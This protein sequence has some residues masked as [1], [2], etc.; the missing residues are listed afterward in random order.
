MAERY[1]NSGDLLPG[2]VLPAGWPDELRKL[3]ARIEQAGTPVNCLIAQAFAEGV[4][5]GLELARA[6]EADVLERLY[7]LIADVATARC[8]QMAT[9]TDRQAQ[10]SPASAGLLF[11][12]K[13]S[14]SAGP[15]RHS[16]Y[17]QLA[18]SC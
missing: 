14:R 6:R 10:K 12:R 15:C 16:T 13:I 3:L 5:Q 1:H 9:G 8:R 7:L 2:L 17:R 18:W 4:V 11:A